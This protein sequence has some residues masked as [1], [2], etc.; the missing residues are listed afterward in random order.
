[1]KHIQNATKLRISGGECRGRYITTIHQSGLRPTTDA[2]RQAIFNI[3]GDTIR[4]A[5][6][7][8]FYSG[9]GALGFE[10]LSRGAASACFVEENPLLCDM[11]RDNAVSLGYG[12]VV[13]I[14]NKSVENLD[15][16]FWVN[17]KFDI[18]FADPPY[19]VNPVSG[20]GFV[21]KSLSDAGLL[22]YEHSDK[23][24]SPE[25][26][27]ELLLT[28]RRNSGDTSVSFYRKNINP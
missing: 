23:S 22:I 15:N 18:V 24:L 7:A 13:S 28:K 5:E 27:G 9:T 10:S 1:M 8:D 4:D 25:A 17:K 21:S 19:E 20:I 16:S 6:V 14:V 11:I 12:D 2:N 3:L 26:L